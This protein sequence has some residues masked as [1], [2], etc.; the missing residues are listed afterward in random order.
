MIKA[1]SKEEQEASIGII[2]TLIQKAMKYAESH[3]T[4]ATASKTERLHDSL[5]LAT[6]IDEGKE[7][8]NK[9]QDLMGALM[10]SLRSPKPETTNGVGKQG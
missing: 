8:C 7:F 4:G 2:R 10:E 6:A 9:Q 3:K 1:M 5:A